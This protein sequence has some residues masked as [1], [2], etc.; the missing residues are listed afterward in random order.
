MCEKYRPAGEPSS[1]HSVRKSFF[2][3]T[4]F[5]Q[6]SKQPSKA[7]THGR[8][9]KIPSFPVHVNNWYLNLPGPNGIFLQPLIWSPEHE[10]ITNQSSTDRLPGFGFNRKYSLN[11]ICFYF[12]MLLKSRNHHLFV[13]FPWPIAFF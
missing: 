5:K 12:G 9:K 8:A 3:S 13:C 4:K 1:C 2:V 7:S 11:E 10:I 6:P